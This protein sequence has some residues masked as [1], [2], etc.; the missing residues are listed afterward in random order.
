[1]RQDKCNLK[2]MAVVISS[3]SILLAWCILD[4]VE[5]VSK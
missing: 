3:T 4:F 1:M 2:E 5:P